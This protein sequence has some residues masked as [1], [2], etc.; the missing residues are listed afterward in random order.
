MSQVLERQCDGW[1][2]PDPDTGRALERVADLLAT[3]STDI[4]ANVVMHV[5]AFGQDGEVHKGMIG[6]PL[7]VA[8]LVSMVADMAHKQVPAAPPPGY[9]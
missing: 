8:C 5:V 6:S 9:L 4:P 2:E 3:F 7:A 1:A